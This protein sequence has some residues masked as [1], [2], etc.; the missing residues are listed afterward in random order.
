MCC[1]RTY[2]WFHLSRTSSYQP[3]PTRR[4]F[5]ASYTPNPRFKGPN[6]YERCLMLLL[7]FLLLNISAWFSCFS[8]VMYHLPPDLGLQSARFKPIYGVYVATFLCEKNKNKSKCDYAQK[9][10]ESFCCLIFV[11]FAILCFNHSEGKFRTKR[12]TPKDTNLPFTSIS[13]HSVI[14][15]L[16]RKHSITWQNMFKI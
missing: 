12:K 5:V 2:L 15:Q 10:K 1:L 3:A 16:E 9:L 4:E 14:L 7:I 8:Y 6:I 11:S 13:A